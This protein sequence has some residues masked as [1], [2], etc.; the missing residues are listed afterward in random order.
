MS[1]SGR[2][3]RVWAPG[4]FA[5]A[6][7]GIR[8]PALESL[9]A[10]AERS[11][12]PGC[13][14]AQWLC[15][16]F[17]IHTPAPPVAALMR[18]YDQGDAG[19]WAWLHADPVQLQIGYRGA[20]L[21]VPAFAPGEEAALADTVADAFSVLGA[22]LSV[23]AP[24]RW[25]LRMRTLPR[26]QTR[27]PAEHMGLHT[28]LPE[29][30]DRAVWHQAL[31]EAQM[32]LH[33]SAINQRRQARGVPPVDS[34]WCWGGGYLPPLAASETGQLYGDAP[35]ALA[36]AALHGWQYAPV[37]AIATTLSGAAAMLLVV[38]PADRWTLAELEQGWFVP[39]LD[40]LR[41]GELS[42]VLIQSPAQAF[43]VEGRGRLMRF[44]RRPLSAYLPE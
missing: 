25:Y 36:L 9:L 39:L 11:R 40:A 5:G 28:L 44:W 32:R 27:P 31:N 37:P 17:G 26:L 13:S 34:L 15:G 2:D 21:D 38:L 22:E 41:R 19:D 16:H 30:P 12:V 24:G 10:R 35:L 3:A 6:V 4:L 42:R 23:G 14:M 33:D 43:Q 20:R 18:Q 8:Y 1:G 7:P 29:G